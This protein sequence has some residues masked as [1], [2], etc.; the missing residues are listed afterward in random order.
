MWTA[1]AILAGIAVVIGIIVALGNKNAKEWENN[2]ARQK[3]E[4]REYDQKRQNE[5]IAAA[6]RRNRPRKFRRKSPTLVEE[7]D[8]DLGDWIIISMFLFDELMESGEITHGDVEYLNDTDPRTAPEPAPAPEP[9]F[10][11]RE[12]S[13]PEPVRSAVPEPVSE[14]E[15]SRSSFDSGYSSSDSG[16]SYDSGSSDSGS[17]D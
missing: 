17:C 10:E 8:Y 6:K 15:P 11:P 9:V 13:I 16:G 3:R 5:G 14:P 1:I 12:S 7:W 4:R 2:N